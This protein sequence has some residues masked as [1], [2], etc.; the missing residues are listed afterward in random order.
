MTVVEIC[1]STQSESSLVLEKLVKIFLQYSCLAMISSQKKPR[2]CLC[3]WYPRVSELMVH[4]RDGLRMC[5]EE[6]CC[7]IHSL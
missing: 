7:F 6:I 1:F 3:A 5:V 4:L 2:L